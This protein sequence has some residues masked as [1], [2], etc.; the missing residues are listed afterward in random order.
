MA[1]SLIWIAATSP[2]MRRQ[3]EQEK[4]SPRI[5]WLGSVSD[6]ELAV[7]LPQHQ[8]LAVPSSYEG[9]GIVYLEAMR[10][11]LPVIAGAAGGVREIVRPGVDGFLTPPG[12]P[13]AL[14][15]RLASLMQDRELLARLSLA[16]LAGAASHPTWEASAAQVRNAS[17]P[18]R[19]IEARFRISAEDN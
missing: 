15:R 11:G 8:L 7:L 14:S 5:T 4:V 13:A 19:E 16:A 12:D 2:A 17:F 1:G 9:F 3:V 18:V 10:F 6:Q